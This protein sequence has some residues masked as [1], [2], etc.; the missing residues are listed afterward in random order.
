MPMNVSLTPELEK[1]VHDKVSGGMYT[2]ASEVVRESLRIM[3]SYEDLQQKRIAELND[4]IGIGMK[5]LQGGQKIEGK[6]SRKKIK[7]KID[8]IAKGK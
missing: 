2:S 8:L 6:V 4:A 5:Q 1:Y 7:A 3:H